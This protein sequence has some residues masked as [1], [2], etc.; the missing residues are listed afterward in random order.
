MMTVT[1]KSAPHKKKTSGHTNQWI[2]PSQLQHIS[3]SK[4][5]S[6]TARIYHY[7]LQKE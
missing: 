3:A 6:V 2:A 1:K 4:Q 5:Y 7:E